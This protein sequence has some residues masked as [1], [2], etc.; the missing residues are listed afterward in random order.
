MVLLGFAIYFIYTKMSYKNNDE[1]EVVDD[2]VYV[3]P[4]LNDITEVPDLRDT[5]FD[6]SNVSVN[7]TVKTGRD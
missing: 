4:C 5:T 3:G 2:S 1:D 7:C 6:F